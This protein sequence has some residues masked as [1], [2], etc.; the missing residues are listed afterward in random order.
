MKFHWWKF[1]AECPV[2]SLLPSPQVL[3]GA[4][5][6]LGCADQRE[7]CAMV[8]WRYLLKLKCQPILS[9]HA[10]GKFWGKPGRAW[11]VERLELHSCLGKT[12]WGRF[13]GTVKPKRKGSHQVTWIGE[14]S[15]T[16]SNITPIS[17]SFSIW[18]FP[19]HLCVF[20]ALFL[21]KL[22][23]LGYVHYGGGVDS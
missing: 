12:E 16:Q 10:L 8:P 4:E 14:I 1:V 22:F 15:M 23:L 11:G 6:I 7:G 3:L 20:K 21:Y 5:E 19:P 2:A 9:S 13:L 17:A 18:A